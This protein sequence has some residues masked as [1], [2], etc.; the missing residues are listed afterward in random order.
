[1]MIRAA[2]TED[3]EALTK[4][5]FASKNYWNYPKEYFEIWKNELTISRDYIH[6]NDVFVY[7]KDGSIIGYYSM[8]NLKAGIEISGIPIDKGIWLEHMFI[9]PDHIGTGI[10]T[11]LFQ[12]MR[13]RCISADI[14]EVGIL[15]DPNARGFWEKMGCV[16]MREYPST[17][18]GRTTPFL[19]Y[20]RCSERSSCPAK[21]R[22]TMDFVLRDVTKSDFEWLYDLRLQTMSNY[23]IASGDQFIRERQTDRI[24]KAYESI[25]IIRAEDQDI[26]M[27]KVRRDTDMWEIVQIQLLP[28]YQHRGIG[29]KLI[30]DL[31]AEAS[32]KG[33]PVVLSV[34]KVNPAKHLY[35]KLGFEVVEEKEKSYTMRYIA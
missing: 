23:I 9:D 15:A 28:A 12:H 30:R 2:K 11:K 34:L 21:M 24:M 31:Q 6:E 26:G 17:I 8:V 27:F 33:I 16:Y 4:I 7:E 20:M 25:K 14:R 29:S 32:H 19:K 13:E 22:P 10:G 5:S 35:E 1:M 18:E 3:S